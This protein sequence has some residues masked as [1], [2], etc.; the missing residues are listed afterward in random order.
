SE[1]EAIQVYSYPT[2]RQLSEYVASQANIEPVL[3]P[4]STPA[5]TRQQAT[6]PAQV[7]EV[8]EEPGWSGS[9]PELT[10]WRT[11]QGVSMMSAEPAV[12]RQAVAIIG[13]AG[14]FPQ[15][16]TLDEY[17]SNLASGR[18]CIEEVGA[19]WDVSQY[20]TTGDLGSGQTNSKWLG[21]LDDYDLF[22]PLFFNISPTEA[23]SMDPQ[24]RLFLQSSWHAIEDAGYSADGLS[25]SRCGVFV[26][27]A[28]GD[29]HDLSV[30]QQHSA[31]SFTGGAT[32]ILAARISYFLD[33]QGPCWSVDTACS[34]S[35]VSIANACDSLNTGSSDLALAGGV[36]V[37]SGPGMHIKTAQSGMLSPD[38]RCFTFDER[39][40]GFV[41][42]EG[43]GV[44]LLKRLADA[45]Q[46]ADRIHAV[47]AGWGVNQDG[48]TNGIT[49]PSA[50]SQMRLEQ[51]VYDR[52]GINPEQ[53]QLIEAHGTGTRLG[54]P[55]E[56]EG[57]KSA[58]A[59]YTDASGYCAVGSVKSNIGHCLTAAGVAGVLKLVL[60]LKHRQLPPTL[61]V[62]QANEHIRLSGSPFYLNSQLR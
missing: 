4:V 59:K 6:V 36:Y 38:G 27:C 18:D 14:Q 34:S 48:K 50:Q 23:E 45:Q 3:T 31:R 12:Q 35:L 40:N 24:Q 49:A 21:A 20:Y 29:Y 39:A 47:I 57:L 5:V 1:V 9:W 33:L 11:E 10:S 41:P 56:I 52:H 46:A 51:E 43:V 26:G 17:W 61:H 58:F 8:F 13:M 60:A 15:A 37:M 54:D 28:S 16:R 7:L 44:V 30:D 53:I 42:G 25:G 22:D 19:R 55:I 2:L 32:S 62:E